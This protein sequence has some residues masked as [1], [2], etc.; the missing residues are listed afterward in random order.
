MSDVLERLSERF[1]SAMSWGLPDWEGNIP[2]VG[3]FT[4]GTR[5]VPRPVMWDTVVTATAPGVPGHELH[6]AVT[7][8]RQLVVQEDVPP[9]ALRPLADAVAKELD[10]PFCAVA[11]RDEGDVWA[12]AANR[13]D[14]V[15]LAD[16]QSRQI[17]VSRVDGELTTRV[18]GSDSDRRFAPLEALLDREEG[19]AT[20]IAHRFIG[21]LWIADTFPL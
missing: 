16:A 4:P 10:S 14:P 18:D 8:T 7:G 21:A 9:S 1:V 13:A 17:E 11:V 5:G 20:V 6:F 2:V 19:D 15:D 3:A 12:A